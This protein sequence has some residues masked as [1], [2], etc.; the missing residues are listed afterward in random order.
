MGE[1]PRMGVERPEL[2]DAPVRFLPLIG[3]PY[4]LVYDAETRPP[5]ILRGLHGARDLAGALDGV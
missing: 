3:F 5:L 4:V 1:H 2:A